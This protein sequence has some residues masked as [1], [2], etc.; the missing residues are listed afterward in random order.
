MLRL[1]AG[2]PG[3][4]PGLGLPDDPRYV[5]EVRRRV[6]RL[7][8][9]GSLPS[10]VGTVTGQAGNREHGAAVEVTLRIEQ[11]RIAEAR[12]RAFGCP[13]LLA[14]ASRAMECITGFGVSAAGTWAWEEVARELQV[15]AAKFGRL[16]TLQ[17]AIRAAVRNWSGATRST[18]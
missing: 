1:R 5:A 14:A 4:D 3:P 11:D 17:D 9:W 2:E 6:D 13:H 12:F 16:I 7:A 10:G 18:V 8:G 15:P